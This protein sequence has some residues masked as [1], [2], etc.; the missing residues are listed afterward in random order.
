[1][2]FILSVFG[3]VLVMEGIPY[4]AFPGKVKRWALAIQEI[5]DSGL[6]AMG[7][8]SMIAGLVLLYVAGY[9]RT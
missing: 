3:V 1:M 9:M 6:R 5:P 8:T 2:A 7:I 4:F